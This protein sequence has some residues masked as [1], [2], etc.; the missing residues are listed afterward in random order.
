MGQCAK[1]GVKSYC[2]LRRYILLHSN[3]KIR[4]KIYFAIGSY[5]GRKPKIAYD[6]A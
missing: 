5:I 1:E 6:H 4:I 2:M 3:A